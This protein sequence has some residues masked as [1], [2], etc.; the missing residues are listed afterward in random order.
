MDYRFSIGDV[1]YSGFSNRYG[2]VIRIDEA[3]DAF[4]TTNLGS[5]QFR[6]LVYENEALRAFVTFGGPICPLPMMEP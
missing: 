5:D 3:D 2:R 4:I 6:A 1:L